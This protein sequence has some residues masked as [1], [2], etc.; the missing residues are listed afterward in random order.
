MQAVDGWGNF[1]LATG[2]AAAAVTALL[3]VLVLTHNEPE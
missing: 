3:F 2:A 1:Y